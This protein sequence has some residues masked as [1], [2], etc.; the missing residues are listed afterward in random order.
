MGA[1]TEA[2]KEIREL[3][4]EIIAEHKPPRGGRIIFQHT[5]KTQTRLS[6]NMY[7]D[8]AVAGVDNKFLGA[9][10]TGVPGKGLIGKGLK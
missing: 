2:P 1:Y 5:P 3:I 6:S 4:D 9:L 10:N 8:T 7:L